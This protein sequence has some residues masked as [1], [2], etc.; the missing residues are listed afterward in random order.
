M[1][2][3][4]FRCLAS[5]AAV[6]V[7]GAAAP[8]RLAARLAVRALHDELSLYPKPGLVSPRDAGSHEDMDAGTFLRSLF[9]LRHYYARIAAAGWHDA[10]FPVLRDL[11]I[12]AETRMLRATGGVNTHRGA[13]F[14]LGLLAAAGASL[15]RRGVPPDDAAW[16]AEVPR[17]WGRGLRLAGAAAGTPS[18]GMQVAMRYRAS[19][20][21]G[22]AL[23]GFPAVF[24][25]A[26]PALRQAQ[27]VGA[28]WQ[29]T[30]LHAFFTLLAEVEDTN[31]L[32]RGGQAGLDWMRGE[33]RAFLAGGS[34][35]SPGWFARAQAM[36]RQACARRLSPGGSADML[37][38]ACFVFGWQAHAEAA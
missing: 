2:Q 27:S 22:E 4:A 5:Q 28:D 19:G 36:H 9:A 20:A 37:A 15:W 6:P 25:L 17:R 38:A 13:I 14:A 29:A 12:A 10:D 23:A 35:F 18:H 31:L 1:T 34:V 30:R 24:D 11:G 8:A 33:A 32:Y 26:L 16:R 21:R 3:Q 7:S